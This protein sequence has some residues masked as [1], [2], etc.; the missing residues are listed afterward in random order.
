MVSKGQ[1]VTFKADS[2]YLEKLN[3]LSR[4]LKLD[5]SKTIRLALDEMIAKY[6]EPGYK[7]EMTVVNNEFLDLFMERISRRMRELEAARATDKEEIELLRELKDPAI[8]DKIL[9]GR[10]YDKEKK[11]AARKSKDDKAEG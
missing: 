8:V 9:R 6:T 1:I 10:E 2:Q 5:R 4:E 7:G 3:E 11:E